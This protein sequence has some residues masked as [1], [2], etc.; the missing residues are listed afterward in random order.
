MGNSMKHDLL[1][2]HQHQVFGRLVTPNFNANLIT[3]RG[4]LSSAFMYM[5]R[6]DYCIWN[7]QALSEPDD[8]GLQ[9]TYFCVIFIFICVIFV[10]IL[11]V[12]YTHN[13][14]TL[15]GHIWFNFLTKC[16]SNRRI[17]F[18]NP[19]PYTFSESELGQFL[20]LLETINLSS[21]PTLCTNWPCKYE[22]IGKI[23]TS[24]ASSLFSFFAQLPPF[25]HVQYST[26]FLFEQF[27]CLAYLT[28]T[29][30]VAICTSYENFCLWSVVR[31][32]VV[33]TRLF[34]H[35]FLTHLF[36]SY[37]AKSGLQQTRQALFLA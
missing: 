11:F 28:P 24:F 9:N 25:L 31:Q 29:L 15:L 26:L 14:A 2:Q 27:L 23:W 6:K 30:S 5:I 3:N 37:C 16:L 1:I 34:C 8:V 17:A 35:L 33:K 36:M 20:K 12:N 7:N 21:M 19:S 4:Q 13:A 22:K 18:E 32:H 10:C